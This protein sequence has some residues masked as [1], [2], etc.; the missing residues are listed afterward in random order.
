VRR[1]ISLI[2]VVLA[3][4]ACG[5]ASH[6][7]V[8][9]PELDV[10]VG[11]EAEAD[12]TLRRA[13]RLLEADAAREAEPL[14]R[15]VL[16]LDPE[17]ELA[18]SLLVELLTDQRRYAESIPLL[19]AVLADDPE[20]ARAHELLTASLHEKG[21]L[22]AADA[23]YQA[24]YALDADSDVAL[25]GWGRV[26][27]EQGRFDD[28]RKAFARAEK[29]RSGRADVR[30]ELGL[31]L[32]ALGKLKAAEAKQRDALERDPRSADAWFRLGDVIFE[33][34]EGR[35]DEAI[36]ALH[37]AVRCDPG[38]VRAQVHLYRLLREAVL[39]GASD[40]DG[41]SD[42]RWRAV[43]RVHERGQV[44]ARAGAPRRHP[45][46][47]A[48]EERLL[49]LL[50]DD[51]DDLTARRALGEWLHS[52]GHVHAAVVEYDRVL[53]GGGADAALLAEAGAAHLVTERLERSVELLAE[54]VASEDCPAVAR[55]H[56]AW[57]L[58]VLDRAEESAAVSEATLLLTPADRSARLVHGLAT[59]RLGRLD[60]GLQ[61]IAA[62]GWTR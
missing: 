54:S 22:V 49:A 1:T 36:E 27:Y 44:G 62:G 8:D 46:G 60:E 39:A 30:S 53:E 33:R 35:R 61:E 57:A 26:L 29:R 42:R 59:M 47:A 20:D 13:S 28:A 19:R 41:A 51:P 25:F 38:H 23:A 45:G 2:A 5:D 56:L 40:L 48:E 17:S 58:L 11:P 18:R 21:D 4:C 24:W 32:Q 50:G 12:A 52:E 6:D 3:A 15:R 31:A 9:V 55:R 16:E 43:L 10:R 14:L 34:D 37:S 7:I